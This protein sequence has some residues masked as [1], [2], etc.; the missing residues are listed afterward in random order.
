MS[1]SPRNLDSELAALLAPDILVML[2]EAPGDIA[3]E[4]EELHPKSL[5]DVAEAMP[6]HRVSEFLRAL[7][8]ARAADVLEYLDEDLRTELLEAMST[9]QAV[10][11]VSEM[12]PDDRADVLEELEEETAEEI[13]HDL[14][15]EA[16]QETERLLQYEGD[17][18]GGL[19][20]TEFVSVEQSLTVEEAV[21]I[22]RIAARSGRKE[23]MHALYVT[24]ERGV[25]VGV[26][27]LRDLLAAPEGARCEDVMWTEVVKVP[28][29]AD[30]A[31]VARVISEYDLVAVPVVDAFDRVTGVVTVD[32]VIDV[33]VDEQTEDAQKAGAVQPLEDPYFATGFLTMARK[34]VGWLVFLFVGEMF[35]GTAMR[36]YEQTMASAIALTLFIPL[37][38]SSGGNSGGQSAS[39]ITRAL[40]V[41]DV[42]MSDVL[43]VF[44]RELGQGLT[45]GVCLGAIG[46]VRALTWGNGYPIATVVGLSL[47]MVVLVG[48][49]VGSMLP[50]IFKRLGFDPAIASSPFV[51]SLVDVTGLLIYFNIAG[52]VLR[53]G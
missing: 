38:I 39:L 33:I 30:R 37:I 23:A 43:R 18:A 29:T 47:V 28:A 31:E 34:R 7:P 52:R 35:T 32:D 27:S 25:L 20:T 50:L 45:L 15:D 2:D 24:D 12:T 3:T 53:I 9:E 42:D 51:A 21:T 14:P 22:V 16:R 4:T 36:A 40:A 6:R 49:V 26:M 5:A 19:M 1:A 46:F 48:T 41:G 13:L 10:A 17:T 11:L 8:A 44:F